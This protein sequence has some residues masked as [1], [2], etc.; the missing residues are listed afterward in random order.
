LNLI[1]K[2]IPCEAGHTLFVSQQA[3]SGEVDLMQKEIANIGRNLMQNQIILLWQHLFFR[4][5]KP[6]FFLFDVC[7]NEVMW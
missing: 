5:E 1:L 4:L 2:K 3:P 7:N 6:M